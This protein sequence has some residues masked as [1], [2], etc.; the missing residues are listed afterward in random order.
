M[1]RISES[2][3]G[4]MIGNGTIADESALCIIEP[5]LSECPSWMLM[6]IDMRNTKMYL[7]VRV[8]YDAESIP[9][10]LE[11]VFNEVP[12]A[13]FSDI[14]MMNRWYGYG[15]SNTIFWRK[16]G[17]YVKNLLPFTSM[18]KAMQI[19]VTGIDG[20]ELEAYRKM[21]EEKTSHK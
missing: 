1:S 3:V 12:S 21:L 15:S 10:E 14:V 9:Y 6:R 8:V 5:A 18:C 7:N 19:N 16:L 11:D 2:D 20:T 17:T 4:T 13:D